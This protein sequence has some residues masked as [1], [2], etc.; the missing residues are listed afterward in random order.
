MAV[1]MPIKKAT[2]K[3]DDLGYEGWEA[4]VR[5]N[6]PAYIYDQFVSLDLATEWEGLKKILLS[7]NFVDDNNKQ[8]EHPSKWA[9]YE[10]RKELPTLV[11]NTF[12]TRYFQEF[13]KLAD[14][15]KVLGEN[16]EDTSMTN[17]RLTAPVAA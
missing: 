13:N 4:V 16:S 7:W 15:P 14:V 17:G 5:L 3:F 9:T 6:P 11:W 2:I 12:I 8:I 1:T 10:E